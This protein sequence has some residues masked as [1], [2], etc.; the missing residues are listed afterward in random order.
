MLLVQAIVATAA[1]LLVVLKSKQSQIALP[2]E[3]M[4]KFIKTIAHSV[5]FE[6]RGKSSML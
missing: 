5:E 1:G 2:T 4:P 3:M 6:R